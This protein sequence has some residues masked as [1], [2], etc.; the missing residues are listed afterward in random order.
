MQSGEE[1]DVAMLF[2]SSKFFGREWRKYFDGKVKWDVCPY[3]CEPGALPAELMA[4]MA[5][6]IPLL[7]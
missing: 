6:V 7:W 4:H 5:G 3:G 2:A 1:I